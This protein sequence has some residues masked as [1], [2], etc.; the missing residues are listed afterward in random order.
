MP[1]Q[2][3]ASELFVELSVHEQELVSGGADFGLSSTN[4]AQK[5]V[6]SLESTAST[7]LGSNAYSLSW[8]QAINT[9]AQNLIGLGGSI[10]GKITALPPPPIL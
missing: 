10:P 5:V 2:I 8:D 7:P 6:F 9:A 1:D 4:F 3:I